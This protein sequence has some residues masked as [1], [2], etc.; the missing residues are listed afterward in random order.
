MLASA[1]FSGLCLPAICTA[2]PTPLTCACSHS[3]CPPSPPP[4][5]SLPLLPGFGQ[6][7]P[8][9]GRGGGGAQLRAA[10]HGLPRVAAGVRDGGAVMDVFVGWTAGLGGGGGG[11][12]AGAGLGGGG[13]GNW[14][15]RGKEVRVHA[16]SRAVW[17]ACLLASAEGSG[18]RCRVEVLSVDC[19]L[20]AQAAPH[21]PLAP[22]HPLQCS[23]LQDAKERG[24]ESMFI[25][26]CPP[27]A[28]S[29]SLLPLPPLLSRA[30]CPQCSLCG[31]PARRQQLLS[32]SPPLP[33][34]LL[35]HAAAG[36]PL[37]LLVSAAL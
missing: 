35:A 9:G 34:V 13:S 15:G 2:P 21:T 17:P 36:L 18:T 32:S 23:Y 8:A 22:A 5:F 33:P 4:F 19:M 16:E 6:V 10:H 14:L 12:W 3:P 28:V 11:N 37:A 25:W 31:L 20:P 27:L 7:L 29:L 30:S 26:A 24:F 1:G